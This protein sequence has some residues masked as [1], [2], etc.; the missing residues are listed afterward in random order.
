MKKLHNRNKNLHIVMK[1]LS[2]IKK[3]VHL[4][5]VTAFHK[6][7]FFWEFYEV[8]RL[9]AALF[10]FYHFYS[11]FLGY[12]RPTLKQ[13]RGDSLTD[14]M[15]IKALYLILPK[16]HREPRNEVG[17]QC[18]VERIGGIRAENLPIQGRDTI[19]LCHSFPSLMKASRYIYTLK[20]STL[21]SQNTFF[22]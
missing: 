11:N 8:F 6:I 10:L 17:F 7:Y 5:A 15:R 18:P 14:L 3:S 12:P 4:K 20:L 22:S 16:G 13:W 21:R 1:Y 2:Q 19:P 9:A